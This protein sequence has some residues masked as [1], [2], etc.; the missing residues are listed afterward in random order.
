MVLCDDH[1]FWPP[2]F[3]PNILAPFEDDQLGCVGTTKRA[4][5]TSS[6]L[7][8]KGFWNF[9]GC[10]Y[11]ER[12]NFEAAATN[13]VDG[14]V[15][16]VSGR[17][18]VH[19]FA[20]LRS[21]VFQQAFVNEYTFFGGIGFS[22][23]DDD[24]FITQWM[25]EHGWKNRHPILR[26]CLHRNHPGR[27]PKFLWQCMRW[28]RTVWRSNPRSLLSCQTWRSQ[29]LLHLRRLHDLP[30]QLRPRHRPLTH[31]PLPDLHPPHRQD[32]R[33]NRPPPPDPRFQTHKN[34]GHNFRRHPADLVY[35]PGHILFGSFHPLIKLWAL[36]TFWNT[37]WG[38]PHSR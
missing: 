2:N 20:I 25:V 34:P 5:R 3:L 33:H 26:R 27:N 8:I 18:S 13:Y 6:G 12:H 24:E 38:P 32:Q 1:V 16:T 35:L 9:L 28:A 30:L 17:T 23:S 7:S 14:R 21:P 10:L 37:A 22:N 4:R 11:L 36:L 31:L 29:T 19:R 15:S